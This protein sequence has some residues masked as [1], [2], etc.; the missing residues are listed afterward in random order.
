MCVLS[1]SLSLWLLLFLSLWHFGPVEAANWVNSGLK[2]NVALTQ[3]MGDLG[4]GP[5]MGHGSCSWSLLGFVQKMLI[6]IKAAIDTRQAA[7]SGGVGGEDALESAT[8]RNWCTLC[9][10][11]G[12]GKREEGKRRICCVCFWQINEPC[13]GGVCSMHCGCVICTASR[14][15][16]RRGDRHKRQYGSSC[17]SWTCGKVCH[18]L[19]LL[20]PPYLPPAYAS[21][22]ALHMCKHTHSVIQHCCTRTLVWIALAVQQFVAWPPL[23]SLPCPI[24]LHCA[25]MRRLLKN[26]N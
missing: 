11:N 19:Y 6:L 8:Q 10:E 21:A 15:V 22:L 20:C 13:E 18:S 7:R 5:C 16:V 4:P 26:L 25:F 2:S 12:A 14:G 24:R 3:C 23:L 1:L 9:H 17:N